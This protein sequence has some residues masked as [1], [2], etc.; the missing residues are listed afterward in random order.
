MQSLMSG[1]HTSHAHLRTHTTHSHTSEHACS[2]AL[3]FF[4]ERA[5]KEA[6]AREEWENGAP[7][8][9][10]LRQEALAKQKIEAEERA[11]AIAEWEAANPEEAARQKKEA[12]ERQQKAAKHALWLQT[13]KWAGGGNPMVSRYSFKNWFP[14]AVKSKKSG[15]WYD[16]DQW[17]Y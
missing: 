10:R 11:R 8:R 1:S 17:S 2:L 3:A 15:G 7:E 12:E 14:G 13:P 6:R 5:E 9:E 16:P 4:A